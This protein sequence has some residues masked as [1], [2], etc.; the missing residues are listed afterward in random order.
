MSY[1]KEQLLKNIV[2]TAFGKY[3]SGFTGKDEDYCCIYGVAFQKAREIAK[4][5]SGALY[6]M[7]EDDYIVY[8][9]VKNIFR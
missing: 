6:K 4:I 3:E 5:T 9:P 7:G 2:S 1:S 8:F